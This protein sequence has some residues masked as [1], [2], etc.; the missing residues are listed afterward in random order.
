MRGLASIYQSDSIVY[1]A[2]VAVRLMEQGVINGIGL[3]DT[4]TVE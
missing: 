4:I 3:E 2:T 1:S